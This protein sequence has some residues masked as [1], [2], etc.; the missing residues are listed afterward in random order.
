MVVSCPETVCYFYIQL[1]EERIQKDNR[2]YPSANC[3]FPDK[4]VSEID[5]RF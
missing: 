2:T 3:I 5:C 1:N 4:Q